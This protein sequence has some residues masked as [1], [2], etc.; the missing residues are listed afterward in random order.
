MSDPGW[1]IPGIGRDLPSALLDATS[2]AGPGDCHSVLDSAG[3]R[4][5][6]RRGGRPKASVSAVAGL[7]AGAFVRTQPG[8]AAAGSCSFSDGS[9]SRSDSGSPGTES[10][11]TT[12]AQALQWLDAALQYLV[13]DNIAEWTA[14]EQADCLRAIAV[15]EARQAALHANVL[16]AFC[17]AGGGL[18]G[19][20][21]RSPRV[22]LTWQTQATPR[23]AA[24]KVA[25]MRRLAAHP[26]LADSL[27][28]GTVAESLAAQIAAWSERLP[29]PVRN[30]A[31]AALLDAA[32]SG[33]DLDALASLADEQQ[34]AHAEPDRDRDRF[35][36]RAVRIAATLDGTG[37]VE[38]DLTARCYA[39]LSA[40]LDALSQPTGP[41]DDRTLAQRRH[42]ALEESCI[43]LI[44]ADMLP[45]RAG[46]PVRLELPISLEELRR[47]VGGVACDASVQ[48]VITGFPD[49]DLLSRLA[50]EDGRR[51]RAATMAGAVATGRYQDVIG[52]AAALLSGPHGLAA[53]LRRH[54]PGAAAVPPS[55]VLDIAGTTDTIPV[56]LRRAVR[57]RDCHC[58]FPGCDVR[59]DAC[60]VHHITHRK[61][62][63]RH[64]LSNLLLLCRFH[65]LIAIH[66]WGWTITLHPDAT[67]SATSPDGSR[68]LHSHAPPDRLRAE[69]TAPAPEAA[70]LNRS[71]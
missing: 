43:R 70:A 15:A 56:H 27:A 33:A 38:G 10:R 20:G 37:R 4:R 44:A 30:D 25:W 26:A 60:E 58:R 41:E 69:R 64:A 59:A 40:V 50:D 21:H 16:S 35:E 67:T 42:D 47:N 3:R 28:G 63:G 54:L 11:P 9:C 2:A 18:A 14:G 1:D 51:Q 22:W 48:P 52:A 55:L 31:D 45:N 39:A 29:E 6:R 5:R 65:H 57:R 34:R 62:G 36:E 17:S 68:T 53:A 66:T 71:R 12:A 19:D 23:A 61:D 13:G 32:A 24:G 8:S 7:S 49:Y 46:Q